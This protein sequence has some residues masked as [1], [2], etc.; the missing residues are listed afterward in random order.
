MGRIRDKRTLTLLAGAC[1]WLGLSLGT[2]APDEKVRLNDRDFPEPKG[3][4]TTNHYVCYRAAGAIQVDGKLDETSW[5]KAPWSSDFID[6]VGDLKPK[7]RFRTRVK[8]LWDEE[9]FYIAA[10]LEEPHVWGVLKQRDCIVCY[11]NDFEVFIDTNGDTHRYFE[12]EMNALNTVWDL[13]VPMPYRDGVGTT[14]DAWDI[15]GLQ[16]AVHVRGTLN[17]PSDVDEGWS[18]E[19]AFPMRVMQE[20]WYK[21]PPPPKDGEQ[22]RINFS[23]VEYEVRVRDGRYEKTGKPCDNWTWSN[24]GI[25]N[26]H[27]PEMWGIVQFSRKTVGEGTDAFIAHADDDEANG[28]LRK[29]YYRQNQYRKKCGK[30]TTDLAA[31]GIEPRTLTHCQWPPV[32][33]TT[34]QM[35]EA[36]IDAR[37]AKPGRGRKRWHI[38]QDSKT[39]TTGEYESRRRR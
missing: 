34:D 39:W 5:A 31:L 36:F 32:I 2:A 22:W 4:I 38:R 27:Y 35:F 20:Q 30:F 11:D 28:L 24:Q 13:L 9:N 21:P 25:C 26:M 19:L 14:V 10:E 29:I 12:Y 17:D 15:Q 6:I 16:S 37:A 1:C 8:M 18:L 3:K 7:P 23:R 33:Q